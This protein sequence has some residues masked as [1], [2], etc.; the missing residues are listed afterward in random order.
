MS[1]RILPPAYYF[2]ILLTASLTYPSLV[3]S[4]HVDYIPRRPRKKPGVNL[5]TPVSLWMLLAL[6]HIQLFARLHTFFPSF[7]SNLKFVNVD[8]MI[9]VPFFLLLRKNY[10]NCAVRVQTEGKDFLLGG[11]PEVGKEVWS[12]IVRLG[13]MTTWPRRKFIRLER[14]GLRVRWVGK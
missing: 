9:C 14:D 1:R 3:V 2:P 13:S 8:C 4:D 12:V 10:N 7:W 11:Q 5:H 6:L